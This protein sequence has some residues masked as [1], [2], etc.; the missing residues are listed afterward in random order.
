MDVDEQ[1]VPALLRVVLLPAAQN[2]R[3]SVNSPHEPNL[4][5]GANMLRRVRATPTNTVS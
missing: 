4:P 1:L 3:Y 5:D 2:R